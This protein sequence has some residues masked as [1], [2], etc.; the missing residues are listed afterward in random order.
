MAIHV[1]GR[2]YVVADR[3][4]N[5]LFAYFWDR[6]VKSK[7]TTS[8]ADRRLNQPSQSPYWILGDVARIISFSRGQFIIAQRDQTKIPLPSGE[9]EGW[10]LRMGRLKATV[11]TNEYPL[12]P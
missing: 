2:V 6:T 9:G 10:A 3:A 12:F 8:A 4:S 7:A 5:F 11:Y 1:F